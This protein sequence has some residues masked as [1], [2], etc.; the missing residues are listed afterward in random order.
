MSPKTI[1]HVIQLVGENCITLDDGQKLYNLIYPKISVKDTVELDF[2]G[3]RIFA[4]PFMNAAIGQL[5][6]DISADDLNRYL[7]VDRTKMT[8][9]GLAVLRRVIENAKAYYSNNEVSQAIDEVLAK[10]TQE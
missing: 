5:L 6:K 8:P 2:S 9:V 4:S 1:I 7:I 3:V 10:E